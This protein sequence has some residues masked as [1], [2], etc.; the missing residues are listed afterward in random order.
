M[1]HRDTHSH[2]AHLYSTPHSKGILPALRFGYLGKLCCV[3]ISLH[4]T[5]RKTPLIK[6][7][8]QV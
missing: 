2:I 7:D 1:S 5:I 8:K 3:K 4:N 6:C